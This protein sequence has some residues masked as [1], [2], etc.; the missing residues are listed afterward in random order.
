MVPQTIGGLCPPPPLRR[1]KPCHRDSGS[2]DGGHAV[3]N[4][5]IVTV[6]VTTTSRRR[7]R[8]PTNDGGLR[9]PNPLRR[10]KPCPLPSVFAMRQRE[11]RRRPRRRSRCPTNDGGQMPRL[12]RRQKTCDCDSGSGDGGHAVGP[13]VPRT[14]GG[15]APRTPCVIGNRAIVTVDVTTTS[16]RRSRCPMHKRRGTA[17]PEHPAPPK[18]VPSTK[19]LYIKATLRLC[20]QKI[21]LNININLIPS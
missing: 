18:T 10:R 13:V 15:C 8:C 17:P 5:A 16:R 3:E 7:S 2:G 21:T 20:N 19:S 1:R 6:D 12:L 4:R 9:P 14:T 11:W